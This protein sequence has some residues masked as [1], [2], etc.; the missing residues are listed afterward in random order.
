MSS[1]YTEFD[2]LRLRDVVLIGRGSLLCEV[3]LGEPRDRAPSVHHD[4]LSRDEIELG[5]A[6][7]GHL[8]RD[9]LLRDQP[10]ERR[11]RDGR[12]LVLFP[13]NLSGARRRRA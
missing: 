13:V 9:L 1:E 8:P 2:P 10:P 7:P 11:A 6:E 5:R 12:R 4:G 3:E